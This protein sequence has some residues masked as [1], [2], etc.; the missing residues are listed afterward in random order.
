MATFVTFHELLLMRRN[1][2]HSTT[3]TVR[4]SPK[5]QSPRHRDALLEQ[6][7]NHKYKYPT[8]QAI[9]RQQFAKEP[10]R[11]GKLRRFSPFGETTTRR[12]SGISWRRSKKVVTDTEVSC[13]RYENY[14]F[15]HET[16]KVHT[17]K[18]ALPPQQKQ[19][20]NLTIATFS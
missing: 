18:A 8:S 13:E 5:T 10:G 16:F 3:P 20:R 15:F 4:F 11:S 17:S 2:T 14:L 19:E 7:G 1:T 6:S 9:H 12:P